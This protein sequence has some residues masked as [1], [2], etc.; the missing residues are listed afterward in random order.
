MLTRKL[1]SK[2][3]LLWLNAA[4]V[5]IF[6]VICAPSSMA[7]VK[8]GSNP[9]II[10]PNAN[11][12]V[13]A[14][15]GKKV[16]VKKDVGTIVIENTPAGAITDSVLTVDPTGNVRAIKRSTFSAVVGT[17]PYIL[18]QGAVNKN[19]A[20]PS[21]LSTV[22]GLSQVL[23]SRM[24]YTA[25][26]GN[27][28]ITEPGIYH[29]AVVSEGATNPPTNVAVNDHC[30]NFIV[31]NVSIFRTCGRSSADAFNSTESTMTTGIVKLNAGDIVTA[32]LTTY[33][34]V[35]FTGIYK[36]QISMY[37]LSD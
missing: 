3:C 36:F 19:S 30:S 1:Q 14:V 4:A 7:Q 16:I 34:N 12:E 11:L 6:G 13:E 5:L 20:Q 26:N 35:S 10:G 33:S 27:I 23:L 31:N 29:Y 8:I 32:A 21:T 28:V 37:K 2:K 25:S 9:T 22:T 24:G 17:A 15:N 18:L